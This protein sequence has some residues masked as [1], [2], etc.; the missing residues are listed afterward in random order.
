MSSKK[1][2]HISAEL[3]RSKRLL[4]TGIVVLLFIAAVFLTIYFVSVAKERELKQE[5]AELKATPAPV[6]T[7]VPQP[8]PEPTPELPAETVA[9]IDTTPPEIMEKYAALYEENNALIGWLSI[10]D[11]NID[12]PVVQTPE[13][14]DRYLYLDFYGNKDKNGTLIMDTDSVVGSGTIASEYRNGTAPSSNLIIHGHNMKSGDMFGKLDLYEDEEYGRSHSRI[15]FDSLYEEREYQVISVFYSQ[16]F[17]KH[18][19][20]F[21]F[22]KFFNAENQAEFDDWYDNIMEMSLYDT[23]VTA[24]FGDEFLTLTTCSY[25]VKDGRFAVVAKRIK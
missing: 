18:E 23:G 16:V 9:P 4:L 14:E 3:R 7:A 12:Y 15:C 5:L 20:V 25:Q 1:G 21:K 24:Q 10:E 13:D 19:D 17:Y 2:K 11:T 8:S 22:Y 6:V